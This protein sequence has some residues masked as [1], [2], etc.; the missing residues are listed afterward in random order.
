ME[1]NDLILLMVLGLLGYVLIKKMNTVDPVPGTTTSMPVGGALP[2]T[3][4]DPVSSIANAISSVFNTIGTFA[5][6][7]PKTT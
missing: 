4:G 3:A 6:T 5:Q 2:A 1:K 7:S